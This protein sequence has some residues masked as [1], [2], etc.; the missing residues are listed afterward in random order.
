MQDFNHIFYLHN[1]S[2]DLVKWILYYIVYLGPDIYA[3]LPLDEVNCFPTF[4]N[5][6]AI[7]WLIQYVCVFWHSYHRIIG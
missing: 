5:L 1:L 6:A 3:L 4:L 7:V 2:T